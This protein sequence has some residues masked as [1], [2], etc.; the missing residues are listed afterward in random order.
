MTVRRDDAGDAPN[1]PGAA[2]HW[3]PSAKNGVGTAVSA[4]SMVWFTIMNGVITEV[5]FPR[6][7]QADVREIALV[8]AAGADFVADERQDTTHVTEPLVSGVPA[9][10]ISNTCHRQ[11][12]RVTKVIIT[13]PQRDVLLQH[14]RFDALQGRLSDYRVFVLVAPHLANQGANNTGWLGDYKGLPTLFA[15]RG[16]CALALAC[17]APFITTS[18]G[19][20]GVNDGW[21]QITKAG[22]LTEAYSRARDGNI[23]LTAEIDVMRQKGE[24]VLALGFGRDPDEAG[25]AARASLLRPFASTCTEYVEG[26]KRFHA[27]S[28]VFTMGELE[29][30]AYRQSLAAI[31][32]HE[33]KVRRGAFIASLSI[34]W[35]DDRG[36]HDHGGYHVVWP[37]D[38]VECAGALAAAGHPDVARHALHYLMTTQEADG[39]WPQNMWLD[40]R[41]YWGSNQLDE[42][43]FPILLADQLRGR[44]WLDALDVWPMVRQAAAYLMQHGPVTPE[45]RW[46]EDGGYA[47]FTLA[48][49]IAGLLAAADF[50][51]EAAD[52]GAAKLFRETADYWNASL[53]RWTYVRG[54]PLAEQL[55]VEGYYVRIAPPCGD[56]SGGTVPLRNKADDESVPYAEMISPDA[57][58]L[59]RFGLRAAD[60]S[61]IRN[62]VRA[63]DSLLM[64][65][66]TNGPTWHRYNGDGYGEHEDGAPFDGHGIGRGWPLLTGERAHYELAAGRTDRAA[67]LLGVM[68]RQRGEGGL[69]PEQIWDSDDIPERG[70]FNGCPTGSAMPLAWAHSELVK[71]VRSLHDGRVFD[72]PPQTVRRYVRD[73]VPAAVAVWGFNNKLREV[74]VGRNLRIDAR[75]PARVRWSTDE[76]HTTNDSD[77]LETGLGVWTVELPSNRLATGTRVHFTFYWTEADRW[78]G[79]DFCVAV[80]DAL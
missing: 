33:D 70:L 75:A 21:Q 63:I 69:V 50:A 58:A 24:F 2:A 12:F 17:S 44:G 66:T 16:D 54:T 46:E 9:F 11:R 25:H 14:T 40:G 76:W 47:T 55:G 64:T 8:V 48:V 10:R 32:T 19:F 74:V 56:G 38:L 39:H 68:C 41:R 49:Q 77:T 36:D 28:R 29:T 61:K 72:M 37:R 79:A 30:A 7:D 26:W 80:V 31:Q 4:R 3:T 13:D 51:D 20:I 57:L 1:G 42:T 23:A 53:E 78:E 52:D 60:D 22:R 59:V 67:H 18:C 34:P 35:G 6:V 73:R 15:S 65:T 71:L 27:R 5:Y 45:D 62:T 43:A